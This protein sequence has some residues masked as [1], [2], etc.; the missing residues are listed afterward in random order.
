MYDFK[1]ADIGDG[2]E[3]GKILEWKFKKGDKVKEGDTLVI[4]ETDKVN[5]ELPSPV[6]GTIVSLGKAEGEIINVGETVV[7]IDDGKGGDVPVKKEAAKEEGASVIGEIEVSSDLIESSS[8]SNLKQEVKEKKVLATP[9]ARNLAKNLNV[10]INDV[11]GSGVN[12][13]V[14]KEDIE[15]H[16]ANKN[17]KTP[18][19]VKVNLNFEGDIYVEKISSTRKSISK[20][21][22]TAK[23]IIPET[24]LMDEVIIDKLVELRKNAKVIAE[25]QGISLTFMAFISR[26]VVITLK[27]FKIFNASFD[28]NKNEIIYK[29]YINLGFAVDTPNGL[30]V[31]NIKNA[32]DLSVFSLAKEI[33]DLAVKAIDRKVQLNEIQNGTFTITNFGSVGI[34][35]GTPVINYPEVAILGVGKISKKPV[36]VNDEIK[37]GNILPLSIAVDHRIIDGADAGR[38]LIRVKELLENPELMLLS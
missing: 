38:F 19:D 23:T 5:A 35:Y 7:I 15:K 1:F 17:E 12:G 21:M 8:E 11:V 37:I 4:V 26:A 10:N 3:E 24:V 32:N 13:R 31:P 14:M 9:V 34:S 18:I 20:A 33:K 25:K 30:V 28:H 36:V 16:A 22:S 29:K 6:D 27:E 2:I